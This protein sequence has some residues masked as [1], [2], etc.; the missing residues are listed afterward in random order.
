MKNKPTQK[1]IKAEQI[2]EWGNEQFMKKNFKQAADF[3]L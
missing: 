2:K 3:Y 1:E